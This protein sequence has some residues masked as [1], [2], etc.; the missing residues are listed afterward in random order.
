MPIPA[1]IENQKALATKWCD[2]YN[3]IRELAC[4]I[5]AYNDPKLATRDADPA[6]T[7]P[8]P[9]NADATELLM[10][11][12]N[13]RFLATGWRSRYNIIV[14]ELVLKTPDCKGT[15]VPSPHNISLQK[16]TYLSNDYCVEPKPTIVTAGDKNFGKIAADSECVSLLD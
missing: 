15:D 11:A 16:Q 1:T 3:T 14:N 7:R 8:L 4:K 5:P 13:C 10:K 2:H 9:P 12:E 6:E